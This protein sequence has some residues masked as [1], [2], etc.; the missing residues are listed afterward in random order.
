MSESVPYYTRD[1]I[2]ARFDALRHEVR[3]DIATLRTELKGD[4][5][6]VKARVGEL[7]AQMK[8]WTLGMGLVMGLVTPFLTVIL[9]K[10][11]R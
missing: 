9:I 3:A 5:A 10:L 8:M 6:D 7:S 4:I 2:D 1:V 11:W